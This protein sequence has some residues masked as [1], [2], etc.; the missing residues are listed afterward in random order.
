MAH[1]STITLYN[2]NSTQAQFFETYRLAL[3]PKTLPSRH[4]LLIGAL[5]AIEWETLGVFRSLA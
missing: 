3:S 5:F 1:A 4:A 2:W